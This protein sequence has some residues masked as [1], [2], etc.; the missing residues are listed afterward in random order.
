MATTQDGSDPDCNLSL[1]YLPSHWSDPLVVFL[2]QSS[3]A[4]ARYSEVHGVQLTLALPLF[5]KKWCAA[6]L[7]QKRISNG[8]TM[9]ATPAHSVPLIPSLILSITHCFFFHPLSLSPLIT[10]HSSHSLL[11]SS[12][13]PSSFSDQ[14]LLFVDSSDKLNMRDYPVL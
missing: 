3:I 10:H 7:L 6:C 11:S 8:R 9:E 2:F 1:C 5:K 13:F 4:C 12:L 14:S